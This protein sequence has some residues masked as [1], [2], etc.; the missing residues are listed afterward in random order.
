MPTQL[1][2]AIVTLNLV[3]GQLVLKHGVSTIGGRAAMST[4]PKFVT[5]AVTSPWMWAAAAIQG[6]GAYLWILLLSRANLG[7]ASAS[8]GA[9]FYILMPVCAWL[10]FGESLSLWQ[11]IGIGLLTAGVVLV[12]LGTAS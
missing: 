9:G 2:T 4:F 3:L 1:L 10:I 6:L 5:A 12:S 7:I 11:W 8:V